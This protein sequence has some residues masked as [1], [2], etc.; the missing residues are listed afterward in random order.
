MSYPIT[1]AQLQEMW[2]NL[3]DRV[4]RL[5]LG[6][7]GPQVT[8]DTALSTAT[9]ASSSASS[10][11]AAAAAAQALAATCIVRDSYN[12]FNASNQLTAING[13]GIT[14]Y[15]G[16]SPT[17]GA[18][19]VLNS[20]GLAGVNSSGVTTFAI[21]ASTGNVSMLGSIT[22]GSTITGASFTNTYFTVDVLGNMTATS[23]TV[24]GSIT[25]SSG[26][27]GNFHINSGDYLTY[28]STAIYGGSSANSV[29]AFVDTTKGAYVYKVTTNGGGIT[30]TN[31]GESSTFYNATIQNFLY[32]TAGATTTSAANMYINPSGGLIARVTSSQRYKVEILPET[33]PL[34]SIMK[35]QPKSWIDK[36]QYEA[37][38]NSSNGLKRIIGLIAED[39]AELPVIKDLLVNYNDENQPDSVNYDRIAI[40]LIPLLQNLHNRVTQLEGK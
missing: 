23:A 16:S 5:E 27:I 37:N 29:Y 35:L 39:L 24:T 14:V 33:I 32:N 9:T 13:N 3:Q 30:C 4:T 34:D 6:Y 19:V 12:I 26:S 31:T 28:G 2:Q 40:A 21:N 36:V 20:S 7:S 38:G 25:A 8:A 15:A 18:R 1:P 22:S 11:A 17:S 10:A